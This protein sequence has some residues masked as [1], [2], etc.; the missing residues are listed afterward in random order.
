M[1]VGMA[2]GHLSE[3]RHGIGGTDMLQEHDG[4]DGAGPLLLG[5]AP[6][7]GV[8]AFD[9]VLGPPRA[10]VLGEEVEVIRPTELVELDI[11]PFER[12]RLA[13][14]HDFDHTLPRWGLGVA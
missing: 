12:A 3:D 13:S 11:L 14:A 9:A 1:S 4:T 6:I 10:H 2:G 5:V 8:D 7:L